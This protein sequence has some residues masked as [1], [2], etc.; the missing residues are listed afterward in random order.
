M[1]L[2]FTAGFSAHCRFSW[3]EPRSDRLIICGDKAT[4]TLDP[5]DGGRLVI[6]SA[7]S[8]HAFDDPPPPNL[9][10]DLVQAFSDSVLCGCVGDLCTLSE[11]HAVDTI[12]ERA[13][14]SRSDC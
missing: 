9:H 8:A 6:E 7:D 3:D 2:R 14:G 13:Y 12:L 10:I 5:L 11:A 4:V 1:T